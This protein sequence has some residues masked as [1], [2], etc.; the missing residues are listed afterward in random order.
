VPMLS[1]ADVRN[2]YLC[3][4]TLLIDQG[5]AEVRSEWYD[6][7]T[8]WRQP[9][10][11]PFCARRKRRCCA[12]AFRTLPTLPLLKAEGFKLLALLLKVHALCT[13]SDQ[14]PAPHQASRT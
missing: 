14:S 12:S 7:L 8:L 9:S 5:I 1:L 4:Q 2:S 13:V 3:L 10:L 11:S 6:A